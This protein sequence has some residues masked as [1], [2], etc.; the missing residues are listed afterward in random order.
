MILLSEKTVFGDEQKYEEMLEGFVGIHRKSGVVT[1]GGKKI[2]LST[3]PYQENG[4][5]FVALEEICQLLGRT[6]KNEVKCLPNEFMKKAANGELHVA[7]E[8]YLVRFLNVQVYTDNTTIN[9]GMLIFGNRLFTPPENVNWHKRILV[10]P[11]DQDE[12]FVPPRLPNELQ[13]FNDYLFYLRPKENDILAAYKKSMVKGKH[14]R[15]QSTEKDFERIRL[16]VAKSPLKKKWAMEI[17]KAADEILNKAPI[18]YELRDG[19]R[20]LYVSRQVLAHMYALGM[21]YQLTGKQI[22]AE[23]AYQDLQAAATFPDWHPQHDIDVGEMAA[24]V[25]I[26]Y[27]W[28]YHG[29]TKE[30][31]EV[32]EKGIYQ[33][34]FCPF[35]KAYETKRSPMGSTVIDQGNHTMISSSGI[36]LA[37]MALLD[38]YP[39]EALWFLKNAVRGIESILYLFAHDGAYFEGPHYWELGMQYLAKM[40]SSLQSVFQSDFTIGL[41][42]GL[43]ETADWLLHMSTPLGGIFNFS[44][45]DEGKQY[46]PELFYLGNYYKKPGISAAVLEATNGELKNVEDKVLG[47]IW[48]RENN[49]N[50][51]QNSLSLDKYY[52]EIDAVCM[53]STWV[54]KKPTYAAIHAGITYDGCHAQLDGGT[55]VFDSMGVRWAIDLGYGPINHPCFW[56]GDQHGA[57]WSL[58]RNRAESH[59][60][61]VVNPG[62]KPDHLVD[63]YAPVTRFESSAEGAMAVVNMTDLLRYD[64]RLAKRAV[65]LCE[66]RKCLVVRDEISTFAESDVYWFMATRAE[67]EIQDNRA[68]LSQDG[69]LLFLDFVANVP[70][71]LEV[72]NAGP[73]SETPHVEGDK[74]E[75]AKRI[76]I[77]A[78][79]NGDIYIT[80]KLSPADYRGNAVQVYDKMIQTWSFR[81]EM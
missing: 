54:G 19:I 78:H 53:R 5:T 35:A 22:Y 70:T 28:M 37:A 66:E 3:R 72:A 56:R 45:S 55:F 74:A 40:I 59:N 67:V 25:A 63:S 57:R 69:Q 7:L 8:D 34:C 23:R 2:V 32:I 41:S 81:N 51:E 58:Y 24:G 9:S 68:I 43:S 46:V 44:D 17:I 11:H 1:Q 62:M 79:G 29:F 47:L 15:L 4:R 30:Q 18:V 49:E 80:V 21:A 64:V 14:P 27:D 26:G 71:V 65:M 33:N 77:K 38:V 20:L 10:P 60:T 48:L 36:A 12:P 50:K 31:R 73:L 52:R 61:I 75:V 39:D 16:E 76:R 6:Y 13:E 42:Q